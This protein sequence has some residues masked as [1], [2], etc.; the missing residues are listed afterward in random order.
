MVPRRWLSAQFASACCG[1]L[2]T[3]CVSFASVKQTASIGAKLA[4]YETAFDLAPTSCAA[5]GSEP[6]VCDGLRAD[7]RNWHKV[8]RALV[9]YAAALSAMA[10]DSK[11]VSYKNDISALLGSASHLGGW[12]SSINSNVQ[13]GAGD[14]VDALVNVIT[15]TYRRDKLKDAIRANNAHVQSI[16]TAIEMNAKYFE[17]A[18]ANLLA[19]IQA[20][21]NAV[22]GMDPF[23]AGLRFSLRISATAID[24]DKTAIIAYRKAVEAFAKA[25]D[26]LEKRIENVGDYKRDAE[27]L[28]EIAKDVATILGAAVTATTPPKKGT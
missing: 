12:T 28:N 20:T 23:G 15:G 7:L 9:G 18:D 21:A 10:D 1:V 22:T 19:T 26:D 11:D 6:E 24:N 13:K 17:A 5:G 3:S 25:H 4:A 16:A 8:N 2:A 27:V 14:G